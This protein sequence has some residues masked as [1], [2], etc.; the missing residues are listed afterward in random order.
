MV[1]DDLGF[2]YWIRF[3]HFINIIFITLLIRSGIEILSALPKLYWH[4]DATPGTEW[5][6]FTKKRLPLTLNEEYGSH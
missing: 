1:L 4:D 3:A 6:K 5:I 2:P